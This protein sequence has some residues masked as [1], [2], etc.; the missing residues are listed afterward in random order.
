MV[1]TTPPFAPFHVLLA[2]GGSGGHV[3]PALAV[4]E[5]LIARGYEVSYAGAAS[6]LEARLVPARG[7][8]FH[9]L[10]AKPFVSRG[11]VGKA[12][13][14]LT[15]LRASAAG[16]TLVS[17]LGARVVVGTGGYVSAPAVL[18]SRLAG[19]PSLLIEPNAQPGSANRQL[20]RFAAGAAVAFAA[21][22]DGLSC[23]ARLTGVPIRKEFAAEPAPLPAGPPRLLLL[24]GSQGALSLNR[25]FPAVVARLVGRFPGLTVLHQTGEK[26]L[27]AART[28][29]LAAGVPAGTVEL[30]SFLDD[31]VGAMAGCHLVLGR[32]G[33]ITVAEIAAAGRGAVLAPL[34][35]LA[36]NHQKAN[37][38]A[39]AAA[40]A[41]RVVPDPAADPVAFENE[42][43]AVLSELLA[44]PATLAR[45]A[46]AARAAARLD[47]AA[48][49][50]DWVV[51]LG[52][53]GET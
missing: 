1:E 34:S 52:T 32:A 29:W 3:F 8:R 43:A 45:M 44:H 40:G 18:G 38:E 53:E 20:S 49:I 11:V 50:A 48:R 33:A 24:G 39:F 46:T 27:E 23:P 30:V 16:R 2:G 15:L 7:V 22:A 17:K 19:R 25:S 10:P 36:E 37:A 21:A 13:A 51:E 47:A 4:A 28:A 5:E 26:H 12:G 6:G 42:T 9:A 41:A 14:L 31:V 35:A